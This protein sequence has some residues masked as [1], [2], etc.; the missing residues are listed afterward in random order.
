M[1]PRTHENLKIQYLQTM[2]E[3]FYTYR[4]EENGYLFLYN[5][6]TDQ[7]MALLPQVAALYK[8]AA[9]RPESLAERHPA[10]YDSLCS[11]GFLVADDADEPAAFIASLDERER[12]DRSFGIIVNPTLRCNLR[13]WYCY[14]KHD[15]LTDMPQAVREAVCHLVDRVAADGRHD[16]L[17]LSFFG[18][19]PL[20]PFADVVRPI[21]RHTA[22]VCAPTG[23]RP[24]TTSRRTPRCSTKP[25]STNWP[26]TVP[27]FKSPSTATRPSTTAS[28]GRRQAGPPTAPL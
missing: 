1:R 15:H 28:S 13:C 14:E 2:K 21:L 23:S 22:D 8:S 19:E 11:G 5:A 12:A 26:P 6:A 16:R 20:L 27:R 18:G 3:S 7:M 10:L 17:N 24:P 4:L 9:N 25:S